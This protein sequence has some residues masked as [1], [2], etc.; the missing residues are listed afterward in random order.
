MK[1]A[2]QQRKYSDIVSAFDIPGVYQGTLR[3]W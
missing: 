2:V 3:V 1:E